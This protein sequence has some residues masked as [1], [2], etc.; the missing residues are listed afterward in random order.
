MLSVKVE[1]KDD[2][3]RILILLPLWTPNRSQQNDHLRLDSMHIRIAQPATWFDDRATG[4]QCDVAGGIQC[5]AQ[6]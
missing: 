5:D 1:R 4:P 3:V 2:E 6:L